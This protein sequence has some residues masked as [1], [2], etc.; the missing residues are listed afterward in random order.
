MTESNLAG[1]GLVFMCSGQGSQKPGMGSD[2][3]ENPQ[4]KDVFTC[5]SDVFGMD[6]AALCR[7][8]PAEVLND[9]RNAQVAISALSIGIARALMHREIIPSAVLG[10]SLGQTSALAL[11]GMVSDETAFK[12]IA[13]RSELMAQAANEHPGCMS[14]FLKADLESVQAVCDECA[15]GQVL[16]PANLNCPG[17]IVIAG[18]REA[19]ERAEAAWAAAGKRA[20]RLATAGA[21]HTSLMQ[22][23]AEP[24]A[25]FLSGIAFSE[26]EI[27]LINNVDAKPLAAKDAA[28]QLVAHLTHPVRFEE[29]VR[30]L[31]ASSSIAPEFVETGFGGVLFGLIKRIDKE[32]P[33]ACVQDAASM[34][35]F[36]EAHGCAN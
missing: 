13:K 21:F 25:K 33:R 6:V 5:A 32:L 9:T 10:F 20:T 28:D 11:S 31:V 4:V 12:I 24:F 22:S 30:N 35:A 26:P 2:L 23:A 19:V 7:N 27:P 15:Q 8:A 1:Q 3:L 16:L 29:S 36:L 17:Q 14:A 18:E 34:K